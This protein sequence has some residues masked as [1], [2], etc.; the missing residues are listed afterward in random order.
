MGIKRELFGRIIPFVSLL[1][2]QNPSLRMAGIALAT[3]KIAAIGSRKAIVHRRIFRYEGISGSAALESN[4]CSTVDCTV[5]AFPACVELIILPLTLTSLEMFFF[6]L[7]FLFFFFFFKKVCCARL[8]QKST[9]DERSQNTA[10]DL[11]GP[12]KGISA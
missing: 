1:R 9:F 5:Y 11:R 3:Y 7:S 10:I 2:N 8:D 4:L 6:S 12:Q